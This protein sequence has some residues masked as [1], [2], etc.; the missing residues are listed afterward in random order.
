MRTRFLIGV[1]TAASLT[2]RPQRLESVRWW[3]SPA[4]AAAIGL[5]SEQARAIEQIDRHRSS[6]QRECTERS[7]AASNRV[8][9]FM[10][11]EIYNEQTLRRTEELI[12]AGA[13][14]GALTR[15]LDIQ[16]LALLNP[17]QRRRL[18][19]LRPRRSVE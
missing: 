5:T 12:K 3:Q 6:E 16:A 18:A 17:D 11:D 1:L 10:D 15:E 7:V 19:H 9:Q 4:I 2:V 13:D 8:D 14:G